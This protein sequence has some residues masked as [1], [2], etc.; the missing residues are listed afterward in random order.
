MNLTTDELIDK[1]QDQYNR[2]RYSEAL[3]SAE[4]V[5]EIDAE[6]VNGWWFSGLS[7]LALG[8]HDNAIESL[9]I[10]VDLAPHFAEGWVKYAVV[11]QFEEFEEEAQA[12]FERAIEE[13]SGHIG[14]LTALAKIYSDNNDRESDEKELFVLSQLD[15]IEGLTSN[16]LNRIG[17]IHY[18]YN[19]FFEAIKYWRRNVQFF[20][21]PASLFNLGLAFNHPEVSQDADAIDLWRLTLKR[22]PDFDRAAEKIDRLLPRLLELKDNASKKHKTLL[23]QNQWYRFY[24]N[25]FEL[26]NIQD[27]SYTSVNEIKIKTIQ[28][29]KKKL[30]REIELEEG[31]IIWLDGLKIDKSTA[32]GVCD[33]LNDDSLKEYN[34]K[35]FCDKPLLNFL[36]KG[37]H[38]HFTV[39]EDESPL[40]LLEYLENVDNGFQEWLTKPFIKQFDLVLCAAIEQ[41][42]LSVLE[43][44]LDGRR[45][46]EPSATNDCFEG[47]RNRVDSLLEKLRKAEKQSEEKKPTIK[48]ISILLTEGSLLQMLNLF[49]T[50]FWDLQDE[51]V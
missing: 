30:L 10:V 4:T 46:I 38:S 18:Q 21:G 45:W 14:A 9:E 29:L 33:S 28:K 32:I 12:A 7:H 6:S 25:P 13:D 35:V 17:G 15:K 41:K 26:I 22:H 2:E 42:D 51:A 31:R 34:W 48:E 44:L 3:I 19:R 49:P 5:I 47:A 39:N 1:A 40:E 50:F 23:K 8:N 37:E 36:T 16:Q 27:D 11:L 43:V 24:I 20:S